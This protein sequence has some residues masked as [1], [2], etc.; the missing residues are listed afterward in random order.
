MHVCDGMGLWCLRV[1]VCPGMA[2][3]RALV[4]CCFLVGGAGRK[5]IVC[6]VM[7]IEISFG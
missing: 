6:C 3:F 2:C 5:Y 1:V 4:V 7:S